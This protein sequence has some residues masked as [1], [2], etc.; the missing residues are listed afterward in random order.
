MHILE[1]YIK[2]MHFKKKNIHI[3]LDVVGGFSEGDRVI[4]LR[5]QET[6]AI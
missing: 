1:K 6:K 4:H 2:N 5:F 3:F